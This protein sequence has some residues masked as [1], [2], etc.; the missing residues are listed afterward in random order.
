MTATPR[1]FTG[2]V[3]KIAKEEAWEIASMDDEADF[4]PE[5][6]KLTF[7]EAIE[8]DLLS[9]Y[10]VVII[11][12]DDPTYKEYADQRQFVTRDGKEITDAQTLATHI[13]LAKAMKKYDLRRVITFHSRIKRARD[14]AQDFPDVVE[15]MQEDDGPD[16]DLW[17]DYVSG[18]MRT[19]QRADRLKRLRQVDGGG[20]GLLANAR[21]LGEGV[22]VPTLDGVAFVDPRRS[23]VDIVQNVGRAIRKADDKTVGTIVLPVFIDSTEDPEAVLEGSQF[24]AIRDVLRALRDHDDELPEWLDSIRRIIGPPPPPGEWPV[25][26]LDL[27]TRVG[28]E[29]IQAFQ[30][31]LV[32]QTTESW[33]FWYGLLEAFVEREGHARMEAN[34]R[35]RDFKLGGWVTGQRHRYVTN[36][37]SPDRIAR[38]ETI[39][40]WVWDERAAAWD[41]GFEY[42]QSFVAR[43][44]HS[45][46]SA[47]H[48]EVDFT[49]GN[50]VGVQRREWRTGRLSSD[51]IARLEALPGWVWDAVEALWEEAFANL[52]TCLATEAD[53]TGEITLAV[54]T[55]LRAWAIHQRVQRKLGRLSP[56]RIARL[57]SL[58]GWTWDPYQEAWEEGFACLQSFVAREGHSRVPKAHNVGRLKLGT[59]VRSQRKHKK[60]GRLSPDRIARL[61]ALPGWAWDKL[62]ARWEEGFQSLLSFVA[63]EGHARVPGGHA[64][65]DLKLGVWVGTQRAMWKAGKIS[66]DRVAR[67]D[68]LPG[69]LWES[70]DDVAWEEHFEEL[71]SYVEREGHARV[72][73]K[74]GKGGS[75]LGHWVV[76]QR[77]QGRSGRLSPNRVARL[78]ALPG[79]VWSPHEARWEEG[80]DGLQS[81]VAREGHAR[82]PYSQTDGELKLGHWVGAQ[83]RAWK[84]HRLS[85]NRIAKLEALPGWVW[86]VRNEK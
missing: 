57:D 1:Y 51:R 25:I 78:E 20:R 81:F 82:V 3:K 37:L 56:D 60:D 70:I 23:Q 43:E 72:P 67:L 36:R 33:E 4:G 79:W 14:F 50:W 58:P 44:G 12:V 85:P 22:D 53:T 74:Y 52:E 35:E 47:K 59:W 65:A 32:E 5:F 49:L 19:D 13:A 62:E 29:F 17:C 75:K 54:G 86:Y 83:R 26:R 24:K 76:N 73:S 63:R 38:L 39:P 11:G 9:P 31:R 7:G 84:A 28:E 71:Q 48:V 15:W 66:P 80:F 69:W 6:H 55:S 61:E 68:A 41:E 10:Q 27:P 18:K 8:R 2:R 16:G 77:V 45:R 42:L 46:V 64:E 30:T 21:C 34:H 40:G